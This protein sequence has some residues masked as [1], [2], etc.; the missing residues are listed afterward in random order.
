MEGRLA[1]IIFPGP[2][3]MRAYMRGAE[4]SGVMADH[5]RQLGFGAR[6]Q[7]MRILMCCI[8]RSSPGRAR[9]ALADRRTGA[10]SLCRAP[11]QISGNDHRPAALEVDKPIDSVC[12][13]FAKAVSNAPGSVLRRHPLGDKVMFNGYEMW[14][15]DAERCTRYRLTNQRGAACGRCMKTCPLNKG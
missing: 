12:S 3:S 4:I 13:N 10:Q 7:T 11:L 9:R 2:Q 6:P 8:S 5:L 14:K 1:M 15:I